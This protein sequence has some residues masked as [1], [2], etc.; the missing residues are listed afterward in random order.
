MSFEDSLY[1]FLKVY[2]NLPFF[3]KFL[4]GKLYSLI[5]TR[6]RH[7]KFYYT[8]MKR[9]KTF[10]PDDTNKLL[11]EQLTFVSE[12]INYYKNKN[13]KKIG[14]FPVMDK[15]TL[16]KHFNDFVN[17]NNLNRIKTNTGGSS[18]TPFEFFIEKNI[19]RPKEKAH[20]D[21]YW[22]K[23][24]YKKGDKILMIRG[25]SLANNSLYEY[26]AI[27]NK[28]AI[29]CYLLNKDNIDDIILKIN[30]FNPRFIHAYPFALKNFVWLAQKSKIKL[31]CTIEAAFL[32]SEALY[33]EDQQ[34]FS[35]FFNTK[36]SNFYGHSERLV[37][38]GNCPYTDNLHIFPFYGYE[39]LLGDD[40]KLISEPGIKGR[41]IATGFDNTVM[42]LIRYDTG[43][44]A[45]YALETTCKCGFKGKSFSVIYGRQQDYIFL[46]D[47]TKVSLT[48]FI[49]GQ[50]F[51]EFS[52]IKEIQLEQNKIGV[53]LIRITLAEN[54][55]F[56][57]EPFINKFIK[58]VDNKLAVTVKIVNEIPKTTRGK[59]VFLIQNI[60]V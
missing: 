3:I 58:S 10:G 7:G 53:L 13:F 27:E 60:K 17:S 50:H 15:T 22:E 56:N 2:K 39:E 35:S 24:G 11:N 26:Q 32:G 18:G 9:I 37:H 59:H 34:L 43:D 46:N 30:K 47:Q 44:E 28:F 45:E 29:S 6:I 14:D 25:E 31:K 33:K 38:A 55:V 40:G 8:Y 41:I 1:P 51:S 19:S 54:A 12:N 16:R 52:I 42:P 5:P 4:L 49:F 36:I 57:E 48:A 20:Y 23:F 21:W